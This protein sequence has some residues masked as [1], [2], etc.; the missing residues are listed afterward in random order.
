M[1]LIIVF[2]L[3]LQSALA[4]HAAGFAGRA[5]GPRGFAGDGSISRGPMARGWEASGPRR[6]NGFGRS[7]NSFSSGYSPFFGDYGLWGDYPDWADY[8]YADD[9]YGEEPWPPSNAFPI[10]PS[11]PV[12]GPSSV[13][14]LPAQ[15]V[16]HEYPVPPASAGSSSGATAFTI[17]LKD[18]SQLFAIAA[19][20]QQG[21]LYYVDS[22]QRHRVVSPDVIDRVTTERLNAEKHLR[23]ELPSD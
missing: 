6:G 1:R 21:E 13:P 18:G 8:P 10:T 16:I 4:Q 9:P 7:G 12:F 20:I 15:A 3:I 14:A 17:A 22:Q 23:L 11:A 19:W 5:A 2:A